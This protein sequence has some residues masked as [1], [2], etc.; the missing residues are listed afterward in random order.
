MLNM[1]WFFFGIDCCALTY[2]SRY[3]APRH[4]LASLSAFPHASRDHPFYSG[5]FIVCSF[6]YICLELEAW[7][8]GLS[9]N[10]LYYNLL[11]DENYTVLD[12][13]LWNSMADFSRVYL[14]LVSLKK[15]SAFSHF[16]KH[17]SFLIG[18]GPNVRCRGTMVHILCIKILMWKTKMC[19]YVYRIT[20]M[21]II[22]V[23][24]HKEAYA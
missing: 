24:F 15:K 1:C 20:I 6:Q 23:S 4:H 14:F 8:I 13:N 10:S 16:R 17:L 21:R 11:F 9:N 7:L 2:C 12:R 3:Y 18:H 19:V 5:F 22:T